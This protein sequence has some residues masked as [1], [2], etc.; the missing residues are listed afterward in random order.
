MKTVNT[1]LG[2][3]CLLGFAGL[4]NAQVFILH[5]GAWNVYYSEGAQAGFTPKK[6]F[7]IKDDKTWVTGPTLPGSGGWTLDGNDVYFYGNLGDASLAFSAFGQATGDKLITGNYLTFDSS[8]A[9]SSAKYGTF[10]AVF[11]KNTCP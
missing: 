1:A 7:C 10:K 11:D 8:Q 9:L 5:P 3:A 4:A 2:L 6:V